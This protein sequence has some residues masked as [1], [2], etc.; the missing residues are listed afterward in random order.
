MSENDVTPDPASNEEDPQSNGDG[1]G[2]GNGGDNGNA[3]DTGENSGEEN[4]AE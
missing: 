4:P 2:N 3:G 1:D